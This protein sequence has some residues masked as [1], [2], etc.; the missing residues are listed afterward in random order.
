MNIVAQTPHIPL[1][2][3]AASALTECITIVLEIFADG[4]PE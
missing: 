3:D 2:V 4:V 1:P